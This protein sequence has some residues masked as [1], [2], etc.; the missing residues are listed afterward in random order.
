MKIAV[1]RSLAGRRLILPAVLVACVVAFAAVR[2]PSA[3]DFPK[4]VVCKYH[5]EAY[6]AWEILN[7]R[8]GVRGAVL[9]HIDSHDDLAVDRILDKPGN[10]NEARDKNYWEGSFI[11]PAIRYGLV[12]EVWCI[13]PDEF[14]LGW[15]WDRDDVL[16]SIDYQV[17]E[18][19]T[20]YYLTNKKP[21]VPRRLKSKVNVVE[22]AVHMRHIGGLPYFG[23]ETRPVFLDFDADYFANREQE[24]EPDGPKTPKHRIQQML[25]NDSGDEAIRTKIREDIKTVVKILGVKRVKPVII[26]IAES[27]DYTIEKYLPFIVRTLEQALT[28]SF[29]Q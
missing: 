19:D 1:F 7:I 23:R 20:F 22:A 11:H 4:I 5:N 8:G 9:I 12:S 15:P 2:V 13:F 27:P 3:K 21:D 25:D 17:D 14:P 28:S 26:T 16:Y 24:D 10:L 29:Q 6:N 18:K